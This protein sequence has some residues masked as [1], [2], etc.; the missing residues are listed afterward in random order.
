M[1]GSGKLSF[2]ANSVFNLHPMKISL[3]GASF[4]L[5]IAGTRLI[6]GPA[7]FETGETPVGLIELYSSE[8]CSSCPPAEAWMSALA[9][10][11]GL[12][13][14]FVPVAFH[15]DYWDQLGWPD[16]FA[17]RANTE[18]QE[19]YAAA[20]HNGSV[21]TPGFAFSGRE[22]RDWP[23]QPEPPA[24]RPKSG[25]LRLTLRDLRTADVAFIPALSLEGTP[26]VEVALLGMDLGSD[27]RRGENA[28]R[29]LRH[30]F[31]VLSV[32]SASLKKDGARYLASVPVPPAKETPKAVA[33]WVRIGAADPPL[34]AVGG[35]LNPGK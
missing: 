21:Y 20:W 31:V 2:P 3:L 13:K 35:W 11:P 14:S 32:N 25:V 34:Q 15:V 4:T 6:A 9:T 29:R 12:W 26:I 28:G 27:V 24:G 1:A 19:R 30:D 5:L 18:R 10:S 16:R 7:V 17:S 33:A 8:G 23:N 22:W